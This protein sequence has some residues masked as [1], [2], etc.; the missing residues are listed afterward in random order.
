[1]SAGGEA[2]QPD[3]GGA[4]H[5]AGH[6]LPQ[7]GVLGGLA[8]APGPVKTALA[9]ASWFWGWYQLREEIAVTPIGRAC[10]GD[11]DAA[12]SGPAIPEAADVTEA[13]ERVLALAE[14]ACP[15]ALDGLHDA[16][17]AYRT[18]QELV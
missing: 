17:A 11:L 2:G 18:Y 16:V 13:I 15:Q 14:R 3:A 1:M 10:L 8:G 12:I 5:V 9:P 7:G 6:V 4:A